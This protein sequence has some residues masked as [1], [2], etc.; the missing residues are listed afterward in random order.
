MNGLIL[1]ILGLTL[2]AVVYWYAT[3][4]HTLVEMY[5]TYWQIL[6]WASAMGVQ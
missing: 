4:A 2:L 1:L 5:L 3:V 6:L